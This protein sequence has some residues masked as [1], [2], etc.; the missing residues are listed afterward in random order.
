MAV[1]GRPEPRLFQQRLDRRLQ[2]RGCYP[3]RLLHVN[4]PDDLGHLSP[5][6]DVYPATEPAELRGKE[7]FN[8]DSRDRAPSI[9]GKRIRQAATYGISRLRFR[10]SFQ[11]LDALKPTSTKTRPSTPEALFVSI[12]V[13]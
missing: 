6:I 1:P 8:S 2:V 13:H 11:R 7:F 4:E 12:A 3:G 9:S 5:P 10:C